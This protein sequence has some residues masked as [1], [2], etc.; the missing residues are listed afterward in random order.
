M[1]NLYIELTNGRT[2]TILIDIMKPDIA[3]AVML[4]LEFWQ[5]WT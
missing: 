3:V 4:F 1:R 5:K 2:A